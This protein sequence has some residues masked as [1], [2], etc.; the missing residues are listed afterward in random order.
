M[1]G[2]RARRPA[3]IPAR[4]RRSRPGRPGSKRP[5]EQK[6]NVHGDF[7]H[8]ISLSVDGVGCH[9]YVPVSVR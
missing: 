5:R 3:T 6:S 7:H 9:A 1:S 2:T 4:T 8:Q